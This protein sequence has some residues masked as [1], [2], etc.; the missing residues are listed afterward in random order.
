GDTSTS[1]S[2]QLSFAGKPVSLN[3][4]ATEG[5][6]D[7]YLVFKN[8]KA[9]QGASLMIVMGTVFKTGDSTSNQSVQKDLPKVDLNDYVG[10]Y[11]MKGFQFPYIEVSFK[12]EKLIM[13]AGKQGGVVN[14]TN[15]EKKFEE[16]EKPH[17]YSFVMKRIKS[18][19]C[20]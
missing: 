18:L 9:K 4:T 10:K 1:N 2:G 14:Q 19:S 17:S 13:K 7:I 15:E 5:V 11:K 3:V 8:P 16:K 20:K 12:N 6:H